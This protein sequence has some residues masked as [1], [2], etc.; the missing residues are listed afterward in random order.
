MSAAAKPL[1]ERQTVVI[2]DSITDPHNVGAIIRNCDQ[3]GAALVILPEKRSVKDISENEVVARTS[4]GSS[5][6][7]PLA[8]VSNL[9]RTVSLLKEHGFWIYGADA[10]G[11]P[12]DKINFA[13]RS[14]VI[15]GSEGAGIARLL[16]EQCDDLVSIPTCGKVDSLNVSVAAGILLYEI[17]RRKAVPTV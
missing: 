8:V 7:V 13:P 2:L 10:G 14:A 4:A 9:V 16:S 11:A 17:Y 3:F 5:A 12:I 15:M 6:W 1:E